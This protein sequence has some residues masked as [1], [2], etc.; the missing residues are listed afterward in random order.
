MKEQNRIKDEKSVKKKKKKKY[1]P[2]L[3][4]SIIV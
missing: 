4:L 3:K 2:K 1:F